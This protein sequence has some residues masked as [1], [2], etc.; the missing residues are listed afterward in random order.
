VFRATLCSKTPERSQ[1]PLYICPYCDRDDFP[2]LNDQRAHIG[3]A[4][5]GMDLNV[6][7]VCKNS[8]LGRTNLVVHMRIH[9]GQKPYVCTVCNAR[10]VYPGYLRK[11]MRTHTGERPYSCKTCGASFGQAA[12]LKGHMR[13]HSEEK[14]HVCAVCNKR[15][16]HLQGL[17]MHMVVH[18]KEKRFICT[19]CDSHFGYASSLNAHMR[20][21]HSHLFEINPTL[22]SMI[23]EPKNRFAD[24]DKAQNY[25]SGLFSQPTP[26]NRS[27]RCPHCGETVT[28]LELHTEICPWRQGPSWQ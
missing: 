23:K 4:H 2:K 11:H 17:R 28:D 14:S 3:E 5:P 26:V 18:T 21:C 15:F 6:C 1:K 16:R 10:F 27:E 24:Y 20:T 22:K 13:T 25:L 8:Y 19:E 7:G 12:T 9:K